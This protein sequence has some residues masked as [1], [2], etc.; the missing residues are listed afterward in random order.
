[1]H[2]L[3]RTMRNLWVRGHRMRAIVRERAAGNANTRAACPVSPRGQHP[4][5]H[6]YLDRVLSF[7]LARL[8]SL[9]PSSLSS[10]HRGHGDGD[11][12]SKPDCS[13]PTLLLCFLLST[14]L[15][16]APFTDPSTVLL[17]R[18]TGRRA[19]VGPFRRHFWET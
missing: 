18:Q 2:F 7:L 11:P 15:P 19:A 17:H 6:P 12:S 3:W 16:P 9:V 4:R 8:I 13:S 5:P 14:A 10:S 1:M